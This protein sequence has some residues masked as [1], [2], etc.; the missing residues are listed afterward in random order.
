[1]LLDSGTPENI[2]CRGSTGGSI[3]QH[4]RVHHALL[5]QYLTGAG[6][7]IPAFGTDTTEY[8]FAA[9]AAGVVDIEARLF[10]RRAFIELADLKAWEVEDIL[11]EMER[12][13]LHPGWAK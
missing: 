2:P 13:S 5:T 4:T 6:D 11:M 8:T 1:M 7:R 10:F 3:D 12:I 9:P